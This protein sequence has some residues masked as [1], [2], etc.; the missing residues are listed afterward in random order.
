MLAKTSLGVYANLSLSGR[1]CR[2]VRLQQVTFF[3]SIGDFLISCFG[4]SHLVGPDLVLIT[5]NKSSTE[6]TATIF[7]IA[8]YSL[9]ARPC[10]SPFSY[11]SS[12]IENHPATQL[13]SIVIV[14]IRSVKSRDS[15]TTWMHIYVNRI[16]VPEVKDSWNS[17]RIIIFQRTE[18]FDFWMCA[19]IFLKE[20]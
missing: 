18:S 12:C 17:K 6:L 13:I 9:C 15:P 3:E 8:D 19:A 10:A 11:H 5:P 2:A 20:W 1:R 7:R 16:P 4:C 14:K